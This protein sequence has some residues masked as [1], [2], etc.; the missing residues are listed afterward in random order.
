MT[1]EKY[2][3]WERIIQ[4]KKQEKKAGSLRPIKVTT[5][6]DHIGHTTQKQEW[7]KRTEW[8]TLHSVIYKFMDN[9][10]ENLVEMG[11]LDYYSF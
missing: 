10:S 4:L 6:C 11:S 5:L 8:K 9:K 7:N 1:L 2:Y 3:D